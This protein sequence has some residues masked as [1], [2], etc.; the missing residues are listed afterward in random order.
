MPEFSYSHCES[1]YSGAGWP[2]DCRV[3]FQDTIVE[4]QCH[5]GAN[6]DCHG[7]FN[8]ITCCQASYQ[9]EK[10]QIFIETNLSS[11][12]LRWSILKRSQGNQR[13]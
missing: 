13:K 3:H 7:D 2:I 1:T 5:S 10:K 8:L 12:L 9:G 6:E 11:L 4:G